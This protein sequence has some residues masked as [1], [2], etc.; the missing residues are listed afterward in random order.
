MVVTFWLFFTIVLSF[1][2]SAVNWVSVQIIQFSRQFNLFGSTVIS[3]IF[4]SEEGNFFEGLLVL[5]N[6]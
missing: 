6:G 5:M 2:V 4:L 1:I 3:T